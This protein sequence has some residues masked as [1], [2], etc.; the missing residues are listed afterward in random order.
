FK[1][2]KGKVSAFGEALHIALPQ[3][4]CKESKKALQVRIKYKTDPDATGIQWLEPVQT[5]GGKHPYLFTQFQPILSRSAFP[6][7]DTPG[8]KYTYTAQV[9]CATELVALMSAISEG[10]KENTTTKQVTYSFRQPVPISSYLVALVVGDLQSR[11]ISPR[12]K[13]WSEPAMVEKTVFEFANT[14]RFLKLAEEI[15]G[16]YEW[17]RYDLLCLPPSFPC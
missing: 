4:W 9:T 10:K 12:C 7:F 14:E 15:C 5:L 16:K 13:V 11:D 6:C 8:V 1:V 3:D 2:I 17:T